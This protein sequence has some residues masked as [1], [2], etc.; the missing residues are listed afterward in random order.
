MPD[1]A[2]GP[3]LV[4]WPRAAASAAIFRGARVLIAERGAGPMRGTWSLPGGKIEPGETAAAAAIRE[5]QEET[6]LDVELAGLIDLHEVIRRSGAGDVQLHYIIAVHYG[7]C[8]SGEPR[9]ATDISDA[10]FVRLDELSGYRLTDG[11]VRF[12][13]EAHRR[14]G[15]VS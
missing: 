5:I 10:R 15:L 8:A 11:A 4:A 3:E 14:L 12:I 13:H 6:G 1:A 2:E 7:T 9:A